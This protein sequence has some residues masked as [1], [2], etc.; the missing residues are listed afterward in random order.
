[1]IIETPGSDESIEQLKEKYL[2]LLNEVKIMANE[3][4]ETN[5]NDVDRADKLKEKVDAM[6]ILRGKMNRINSSN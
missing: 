1:M 6:V 2:A 3:L 4:D 5:S